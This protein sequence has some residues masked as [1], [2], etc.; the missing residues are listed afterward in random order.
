MLISG[1]IGLFVTAAQSGLKVETRL[2]TKSVRNILIKMGR[3]SEY[4]G[5]ISVSTASICI[6]IYPY[7]ATSSNINSRDVPLIF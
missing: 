5:D 4:L 1:A 3:L 2:L 6:R 7:F